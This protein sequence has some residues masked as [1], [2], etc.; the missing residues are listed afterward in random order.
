MPSYSIE[1]VVPVVHPSAYVHP[2]A[3][4][5]GDVWIGA[6]CYVGPAASL[7]GDFG[8]IVL[9]EGSN[10]QD[11][12][13]MHAFPGMDTVIEKNG[14]VGH[15]AILHGCIIGEDA[16][17][18]MN[19]V[20]MDE[21][22][23]APRSIVGAG[24]LVKAGFK[25]EPASLIVGTPAKVLRPLNDTEIAWKAKGTEEYQRLTRRSLA[26]LEECQPLEAAESDRPRVDAGS[27]QPK[28]Q[29]E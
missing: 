15:G 5:I 3:V 1:G 26:S 2:T 19:A 22:V 16:L 8:R 10:I 12:C 14:H 4:L 9:K 29:S 24:A 13:V 6:D 17:V 18:G 23:I 7:R 27:Y 20:V 28:H 25:C 11:T 21:A